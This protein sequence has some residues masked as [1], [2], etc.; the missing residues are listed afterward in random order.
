MYLRNLIQKRL[1][2]SD[3]RLY[4]RQGQSVSC[5]TVQKEYR[6][7]KSYLTHRCTQ[8][9]LPVAIKLQ[10]D[11]HYFLTLLACLEVGL[12]YLPFKHDYPSHRIEQIRE[13]SQ[14]QLLVDEVELSKMLAFTG[15]QIDLTEVKHDDNAYLI[16]TS[17]STGRPKGV[18]IARRSLENFFQWLDTDFPSITANDVLLQVTEFTFDISLVDV[19]LFI[20]KN[21]GISF[22]DFNSNIFKMAYEIETRTITVLNTV[23]NNLNMLLS[24]QIVDRANYS[25]LKHLF[26][27]GS[28]FSYGLYQASKSKL[29]SGCEVYNL[30]GPTESTVYSHY[31]KLA[32]DESLDLSEHNV[33][34][35]KPLTNL[36]STILDGELLLGGVQLMKGYVND[37]AQTSKVLIQH[38][39]RTF[40][41]S[42]DLA[43][44]NDRGEYFIV[45][46]TDD[47][48]KYRGFRIN[49]L[50]IDSYI[51]KLPYLQDCA[52]IAVENENLETTTVCFAILS[53][54][55]TVKQF[56]ADLAEFLL[57][58]QIP[59]KVV[60]MESFPVNVSGKV[61]RK[62][63][64]QQYLES[65]G[66]SHV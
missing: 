59:E 24:P 43:F 39:G 62:A 42:G 45:G 31:K 63:L 16:F 6:A 18:M 37:P 57:D 15:P 14:F 10:K 27:A 12:P 8:D 47:T 21:T 60:F 38:E 35:G 23:P 30:Y 9:R 51:H 4:D 54:P 41:R 58:F 53:E 52:S 5:G 66:T 55:R 29:P 48:V 36:F 49:L 50:D 19:G 1:S 46:R 65:K 64:K 28:R 17:G 7:I 32:F 11:Y 26:I 56:K 13:D 61:D 25:S 2:E 40:Y 22:S 20:L 3:F 33:S 44:I 34:I